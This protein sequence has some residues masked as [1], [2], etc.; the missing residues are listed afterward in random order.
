MSEEREFNVEWNAAITAASPREAAERFLHHAMQREIGLGFWVDE[1]DGENR[2]YVDLSED[3][4]DGGV[5]VCPHCGQAADEDEDG[6]H[7]C[8]RCDLQL[9]HLTEDC[10]E[11][12]EGPREYN[13]VWSYETY[14]SS[15]EEAARLAQAIAADPT[16]DPDRVWTVTDV[17]SGES[18]DVQLP[19]AAPAAGRRRPTVI[20]SADAD[21]WLHLQRDGFD[22]F[23][24][25]RV[26]HDEDDDLQGRPNPDLSDDEYQELID[27]ICEALGVAD[28]KESK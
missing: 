5:T 1:I 7:Y 16:H 26:F 24:G 20:T 10:D 4:D 15:P 8:P 3:E 11:C 17:A 9:D 19:P 23:H 14:D 18:F 6:L 22:V 12:Q 21:D 27:A 25:T 28:K 2:V 13:V